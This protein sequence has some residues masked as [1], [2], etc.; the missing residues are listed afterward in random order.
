MLWDAIR[1]Y[2]QLATGV[3]EATT[4]KAKEVAQELL[5]AVG[6]PTS[7]E[8]ANQ[9]SGMAD[10]VLSAARSQRDSLVALVRAE[11]TTV[12]ES[13]GLAKAADVDAV[14]ARLSQVAADV[15]A[16][17]SQ[18]P[19]GSLTPAGIRTRRRAEAGE[20]PPEAYEAGPAA[21]DLE[22][23]DSSEP[24]PAKKTAARKATS[25]RKTAAASG[26]RARGTKKAAAAKQSASN[27]EST[28]PRKRTARKSASAEASTASRKRTSARKSADTATPPRKRTSAR[29]SAAQS[30]SSSAAPEATASD[31]QQTAPEASDNG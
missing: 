25:P 17:V 3:T 8:L 29:K 21:S 19:G 20:A 27:G 5:S 13:S 30:E 16:L 9:V 24:A 4:D 7:N 10:E 12:I 28:S 14:T 22:Q 2:M 1:G 18:L 11:V 6:L 31:A 15:E 26:T 23:P